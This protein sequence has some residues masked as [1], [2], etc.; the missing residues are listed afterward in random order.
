MTESPREPPARS[1]PELLTESPRIEAE[2]LIK[3]AQDA[4]AHIPLPP[5]EVQGDAP[6]Y[7]PNLKDRFTL[8]SLHYKGVQVSKVGTGDTY[9]IT[10]LTLQ[11]AETIEEYAEEHSL[12]PNRDDGALDFT[13]R[14]GGFDK[15]DGYY[16]PKDSSPEHKSESRSVAVLHTIEVP[17]TE[18]P[19]VSS[20]ATTSSPLQEN[21]SIIHADEEIPSL[22][23]ETVQQPGPSPEQMAHVL[24]VS[25]ASEILSRIRGDATKEDAVHLQ[26]YAALLDA[27]PQYDPGENLRDG[28][29][30][31]ISNAGWMRNLFNRTDDEGAYLARIKNNFRNLTVNPIQRIFGI[32]P[33][34]AHEEDPRVYIVHNVRDHLKMVQEMGAP[35]QGQSFQS[36]P[37]QIAQLSSTST[38]S[39]DTA[40]TQEG[41]T[42]N[43]ENLAGRFSEF[44]ES[45]SDNVGMQSS[46]RRTNL[47]LRMALNLFGAG[48]ISSNVGGGE[49]TVQQI[50][51]TY[52]ASARKNRAPVF[53]I[54]KISSLLPTTIARTSV[55]GSSNS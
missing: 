27:N 37:T 55:S 10:T 7:S 41:R 1:T 40:P 4:V 52:N 9:R 8:L 29:R 13:F 33:R 16:G 39:I 32:Q 23:A 11:D 2:A 44:L 3:Q 43:L 45:Q 5:P 36:S 48:G 38:R 22:R 19:V 54:N 12:L 35:V 28:I 17:K 34:T 42:E 21:P 53:E 20:E 18:S 49:A 26:K 51:E 14:I 24:F 30:H 6:D 47:N 46:V 31:A 25:K 15:R 50:V